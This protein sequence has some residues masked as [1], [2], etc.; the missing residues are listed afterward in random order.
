MVHS[1]CLLASGDEMVTVM[2][3]FCGTAVAIAITVARA[4]RR[5]R[6]AAYNA[7]LKQLMI[8][9]GMSALEIEQVIRAQPEDGQRLRARGGNGGSL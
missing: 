6:E 3:L 8:E 2:F 9:R 1:T 7:R 5:T 4:V